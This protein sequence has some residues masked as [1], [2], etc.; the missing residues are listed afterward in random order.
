MAPNNNNNINSTVCSPHVS[1]C[2]FVK[3][4]VWQGPHPS[5]CC[6]R[7]PRPPG[8]ARRSSRT[9]R[10]SPSCRR[11]SRPPPPP[12][13]PPSDRTDHRWESREPWKW[14]LVLGS[15]TLFKEHYIY[16]SKDKVLSSWGSNSYES[17]VETQGFLCSLDPSWQE[18]FSLKLI[19]RNSILAKIFQ[20]H[21]IKC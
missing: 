18:T 11:S 21:V 12:S 1:D 8:P 10:S 19:F 2:L 16:G 4:K 17:L 15:R 5:R 6:R 20:R 13:R 3:L 7:S 9:S 14:S